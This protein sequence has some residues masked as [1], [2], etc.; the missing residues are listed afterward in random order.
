MLINLVGFSGI[1]SAIVVALDADML[2]ESSVSA[3]EMFIGHA[4]LID[5]LPTIL[6]MLDKQLVGVVSDIQRGG[7]PR[8]DVNIPVGPESNDP[9]EKQRCILRFLGRLGGYNK[10]ILGNQSTSSAD[11]ESLSLD[12]HNVPYQ[13][14]VLTAGSPLC[15]YFDR[16]IPR[17]TELCAQ[18]GAQRCNIVY[19][20]SYHILKFLVRLTCSSLYISGHR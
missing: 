20:S 19:N 1:S 5:A 15:I 16:L 11:S 12:G 7:L 10:L 6:P 4:D 13:L 17:I 9:M 8:R 2:I 18:V 3:M 14:P